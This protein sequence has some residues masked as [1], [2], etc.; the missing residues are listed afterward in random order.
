MNKTN[1]VIMVIVILWLVVLSIVVFNFETN[2]KYLCDFDFN[3]LVEKIYIENIEMDFN[4]T[5]FANQV[6]SY[7]NRT[8]G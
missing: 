2:N 5:E 1:F 4:E 7:V 8:G 3:K 6:Y